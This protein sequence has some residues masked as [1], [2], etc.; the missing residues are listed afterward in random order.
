M[1]NS[2][3][4]NFSPKDLPMYATHVYLD[5]I[6]MPIIRSHDFLGRIRLRQLYINASGVEEIQALAFNTLSSLQVGQ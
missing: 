4:V 5:R 6:N 1:N 3:R 2:D